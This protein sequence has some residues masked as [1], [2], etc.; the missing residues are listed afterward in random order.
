MGHLVSFTG[1]V[2]FKN[3]AA[4]RDVAAQLPLDSSWSRPIARI[5]RRSRFAENVVNQLTRA[6]SPKPSPL[7]AA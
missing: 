2:T 7:P 4:V 3:G 5:L 1:I 6:L